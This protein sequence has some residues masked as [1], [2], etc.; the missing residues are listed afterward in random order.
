MTEPEEQLRAYA[1]AI[2]R[3]QRAVELEEVVSRRRHARRPLAVA[4]AVVAVAVV[5]GSI[6][7]ARSHHGPTSLVVSPSAS[8]TSTV[9]SPIDCPAASMSVHGTTGESLDATWIPARFKQTSGSTTDLGSQGGPQYFA[10][11]GTDP[12]FVVLS[13]F[14]SSGPIA[15]ILG[16]GTRNAQTIRIQGHAGALTDAGFG[17]P[18]TTVIAWTDGPGI[19][20]RVQAHNISRA[21][22]IRVADSV[23]YAPG[24]PFT[25]P[26]DPD[27]KVTRERAISTLSKGSTAD[28]QAALTSFG[29]FTAV[30]AHDAN[31]R[32]TI[33]PDVSVAEPV[34]VVWVPNGETRSDRTIVVDAR[35]GETIV[36]IPQVDALALGSLTDRT[37]R[38]C[39]PPFGVLTRSEA[40]YIRQPVPGTVTMKLVTL[41]DLIRRP[42]FEGFASCGPQEC[43]PSVPVWL[44]VATAADH[45]LLL[46]GPGGGLRIVGVTGP[47]VTTTTIKAGSWMVTGMDARTGPQDT[48]LNASISGAGR[49]SA[50]LLALPD[51]SPQ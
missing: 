16:V 26:I 45:R 43:D 29:E 20:L 4:A 6:V 13:R 8:S 41:G 44:T 47:A 50:R 15:D 14:H 24:G 9:R 40:T 11:G 37:A 7:I 1:T 38:V 35:S 32:S 25:Y 33:A 3:A 49:A 28:V 2:A 34:W 12:P 48:N 51:L 46:G 36:S 39:A 18:P 19:E 27:V 22:A 10:L 17:P 23:R 31:H 5:S 30:R 42:E 21:D